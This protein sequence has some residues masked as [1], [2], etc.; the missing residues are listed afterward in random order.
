MFTFVDTSQ[1]LKASGAP[2][3]LPSANEFRLTLAEDRHSKLPLGLSCTGEAAETLTCR[4]FTVTLENLSQKTVRISWPGCN[5]PLVRIDRK[6]P[7]PG[8]GWF[9]VSSIKQENCRPMGWAS[10]R[11]MPGEKHTYAT[12][13]ISPRRYTETFE[14][15]SYTL[16]AEW[17]LFG[18]TEEPEGTD[19]L[20]PLQVVHPPSAASSFDFQEPV[21]VI[22]NEVTLDAPVLPDFGH[23]KFAFEVSVRQG[24]PPA[25]SAKKSVDCTGDA[26]GSI[27]CIVFHYAIHNLGDRPVRQGG[28]SCSGF[29]ITAEY[30]PAHGEWQPVLPNAW[31]CT[32]NI[33]LETPILPGG[34]AEGD[35]VLSTLAP[36]YDTSVLRAAGEYSFRFYFWPNA[37]L[38]SPDGTFCLRRP[39]KQEVVRS[40]ELSLRLSAAAP[41]H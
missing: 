28:Y 19:C 35:F 4:A 22:S 30:R 1:S 39:E 3:L 8:S 27:D 34:T 24:P 2:Q 29:G 7:S 13:L 37:C 25:S 26:S 18:C 23:L 36:G 5:E 17:V 33:Y 16:R 9:P 38:A 14:P 11:L 41:V 10:T 21:A 32:A 40:P 31:V 6:M 15:G 20:G 12:R